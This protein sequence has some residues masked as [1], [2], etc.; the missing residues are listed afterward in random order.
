MRVK[1]PGMLFS[2]SVFDA[3]N[4]QPNEPA[5]DMLQVHDEAWLDIKMPP[6]AEFSVL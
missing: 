2:C 3:S 4:K 6:Y 1:R 5:N